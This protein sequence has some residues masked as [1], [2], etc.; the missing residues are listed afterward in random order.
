MVSLV[1]AIVAGA[2]YLVADVAGS[3]PGSTSA[4][5]GSRPVMLLVYVVVVLAAGAIGTYLLVEQ[6][7]GAGGRPRRSAWSAALGLFAA[8]PIAYLVFV[9]YAQIL[10]P[11]F[12]G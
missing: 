2:I 11:L 6:P 4:A 8:I 10:R 5:T 3:G 9:V 1:V 7:T 12:D